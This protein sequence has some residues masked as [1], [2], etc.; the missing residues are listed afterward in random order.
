MFKDKTICKLTIKEV[1][2]FKKLFKDKNLYD[3]TRKKVK[4]LRTKNEIEPKAKYLCRGI[5]KYE[6]MIS[7]GITRPK[8]NNLLP[9]ETSF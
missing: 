5:L 7:L 9:L 6:T 4:N 1:S 3:L 2:D 8:M